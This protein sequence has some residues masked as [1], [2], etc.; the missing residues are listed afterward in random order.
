MRKPIQQFQSFK[1]SAR[2]RGLTVELS[3]EQFW[4]FR[5]GRCRYCGVS[6]DL[7]ARYSGEQKLRTPYMTIDR[8]D[9]AKHYVPDNCCSACFVCNRMKGNILS[10]D[11]M[12]EIGARYVRP[13]W[14]KFQEIVMDQYERDLLPL[15]P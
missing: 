6:S 5:N 2:Q 4:F 11:E 10:A 8:I 12:Q 9:N 7:L 3:L 15:E 1:Q 13:K 14:E